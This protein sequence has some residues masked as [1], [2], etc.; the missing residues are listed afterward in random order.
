MIEAPKEYALLVVIW[1]VVLFGG[2]LLGTALD[3]RE[4]DHV[5]E[6]SVLVQHQQEQAVALHEDIKKIKIKIITLRFDR[7]NH[8]AEQNRWYYESP[9][10]TDPQY[11]DF[12]E[13]LYLSKH[14]E[15]L[16][17]GLEPGSS[18]ALAFLQQKEAEERRRRM[19]AASKMCKRSP[20]DEV[21]VTDPKRSRIE[22]EREL[23]VGYKPSWKK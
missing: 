15:V 22:I 11:P 7:L 20:E 14:W 18:D 9:K 10:T 12:M 6:Q 19:F 13:W 4:P 17:E 8:M 1:F 23:P 16:K 2:A 21:E 3:A 5:Q